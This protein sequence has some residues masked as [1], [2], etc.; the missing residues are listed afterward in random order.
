MRRGGREG[1][2]GILA[3]LYDALFSRRR[4]KG[5]I[6]NNYENPFFFLASLREDTGC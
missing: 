4:K 1:E 5:S 3:Y 2:E 6:V